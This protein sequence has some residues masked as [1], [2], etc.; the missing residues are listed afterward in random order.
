MNKVLCKNKLFSMTEYNE[1]RGR[2]RR[3]NVTYTITINDHWNKIDYEAVRDI[4]DPE[5]NI[6]GRTGTKWKFKNK[7]QA[8]KAWLWLDLRFG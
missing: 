4:I 2:L 5:R 1:G 8:Y 3:R 6:S 7:D